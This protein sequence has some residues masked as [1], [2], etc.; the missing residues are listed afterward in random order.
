MSCKCFWNIKGGHLMVQHTN[1]NN[2]LLIH[3][4][5]NVSRLDWWV[6]PKYI[7]D[8]ISNSSFNGLWQEDV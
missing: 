1:F 2:I 4:I 5:V 3:S 7:S 6:I 8:Q